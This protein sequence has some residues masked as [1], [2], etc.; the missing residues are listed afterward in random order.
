MLSVPSIEQLSPND[1]YAGHGNCCASKAVGWS[2]GVAKKA[3]L[4]VVPCGL[5]LTGRLLAFSA[6]VKDILQNKLQGKA[7]ITYSHSGN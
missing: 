3:D 7:V 1:R 6:I 5:M 2:V 4:V